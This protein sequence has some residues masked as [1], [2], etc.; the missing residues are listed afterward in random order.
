MTFKSYPLAAL[1][2]LT[3]AAAPAR[4]TAP[5][6]PWTS[7]DGQVSLLRPAA[8]QPTT[9]DEAISTLMSPGWRL[10]W[11]EGNPTPGRMIVRLTLDVASKGPGKNTAAEVFQV[12]VSRDPAVVKSCLR[13]GLDSGNGERKPDRVIN[14]VHYGVWENGDSSMGSGISGIDLRAVVD[15]ACYAVERFG[16]SHT[17]N[18]GDPKATL[19][20][21]TGKAELDA[22]LASLRIGHGP[23]QAPTLRMPPGAVAR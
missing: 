20:E 9:S 13:Y 8:A 14:G 19:P 17:A 12:G 15:G 18:D 10:T 2:L 7:P 11:G 3:I 4:F 6:Q 23:A 1:S 22:T 21:A 16:M 5:M